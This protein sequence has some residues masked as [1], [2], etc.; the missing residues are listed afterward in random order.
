MYSINSISF[1]LNRSIW[2]IIT[3]IFAFSIGYLTNYDLYNQ[4][5][6]KVLC[7]F[8][9]LLIVLTFKHNFKY[10]SREH[11][12]FLLFILWGVISYFWITKS[13][14][15]F[16]H[17]ADQMVQIGIMWVVMFL[18]IYQYGFLRP[19][20]LASFISILSTFIYGYFSKNLSL[21]VLYIERYDGGFHN[22]NS[23]GLAI[24]YLIVLSFLTLYDTNNRYL[25]L[26]LV[27]T[28]ILSSVV[29]IFPASRKSLFGLSVFMFTL[30]FL[31]YF[32]IN[33]FL[34][35]SLGGIFTFI[36]FKKSLEIFHRLIIGKRLTQIENPDQLGGYRF[37]FEGLDLV[38]N[39]PIFGI[40]L[41]QFRS[42]YYQGLD[43]HSAFLLALAELGIIGFSI[44][45][46]FFY[47]W[48]K[49]IKSMKYLAKSADKIHILNVFEAFFYSTIVQ[50]IF[51]QFFTSVSS[52]MIYSFIF[53]YLIHLKV[54]WESI[55]VLRIN[56]R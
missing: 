19:I 38:K 8:I 52:M 17:L 39:S 16:F 48:Y 50:S 32:K 34:S 20:W 55:S 1:K 18:I 42:V 43:P 14:E 49:R 36:F 2:Y 5:V 10:L 21:D 47:F 40:G 33:G 3:F 56:R 24:Y 44:L 27:G 31:N 12:T 11:Y 15:R 22:P 29:I 28:I 7:P 46:I 9:A 54:K 26:L 41:G 30:L 45:I 4:F 23:L 51:Y 53:A 13:P 6:L 25:K 37:L 35:F